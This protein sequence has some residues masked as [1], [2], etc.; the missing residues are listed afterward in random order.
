ME[1]YDVSEERLGDGLGGVRMCQWNEV[2]I[3]AEVVHQLED[4]GLA[5]DV[6]QRLD[7]IQP[8]VGPYP[9]QN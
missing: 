7:E 3:F 8:D 4:D 9:L 5:T 2:A 6:G 1:P